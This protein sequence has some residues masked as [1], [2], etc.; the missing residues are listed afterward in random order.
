MR[1]KICLTIFG[2]AFP[3]MIWGVSTQ[4]WW[5]GEMSSLFLAVGIIIMFL[6][7]LL[8][9]SINAFI[10][11]AAELIGVALIVGLAR[12]VNII[13]DNGFISDTL[14]YLFK[15]ACCKHEPYG[16]CTIPV[17]YFL[18]LGI[19]YSVFFRTCSTFNANHGTTCRYSRSFK[20]NYN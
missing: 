5:F 11:G 17:W 15:S 3:I 7:G 16:I 10:N 4:G 9:K 6:S 2:I 8:K 1:K 13:M 12:A 19:L 14:L 20:G 18:C